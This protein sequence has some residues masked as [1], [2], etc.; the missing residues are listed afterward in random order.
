MISHKAH[1]K[2]TVDG[3]EFILICDLDA[4]VAQGKEAIFQFQKYLGQI[5]DKAIEKQEVKR[6]LPSEDIT[7][8]LKQEVNNVGS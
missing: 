2:C 8:D 1:L 7:S 5:E 4:N 6:D 3:K